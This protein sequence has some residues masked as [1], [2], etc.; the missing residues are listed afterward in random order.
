MLQSFKAYECN[1]RRKRS[2]IIHEYGEA[3]IIMN[4]AA[5][6]IASRPMKHL[7]EKSHNTS[8]RPGGEERLD[9]PAGKFTIAKSE[10]MEL[11]VFLDF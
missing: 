8:I 2:P 9:P 10:C 4:S 6:D 1:M 3:S 5:R 7:H 11:N